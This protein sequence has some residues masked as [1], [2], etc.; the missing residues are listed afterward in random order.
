MKIAFFFILDIKNYDS[1]CLFVGC[2]KSF[3]IKSKKIIAKR[4]REREREREINF[5]LRHFG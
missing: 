1:S 5:A 4:E 2:V 3:Y